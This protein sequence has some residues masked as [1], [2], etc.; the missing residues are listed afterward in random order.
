METSRLRLFSF[1]LIVTAAIALPGCDRGPASLANISYRQVGI[2]KGYDTP[3]G[4]VKA[5][6]NEAFAIFRINAIDNTKP[7]KGFT[8]DPALLYVD[9]STPAQKAGNVWNWN[10]RFVNMNPRFWQALGLPTPERMIV[11][12]GKKVEIDRFVSVPVGINNPTGGPEAKQY[13]FDFVYDAETMRQGEKTVNE[14]VAFNKINSS[15]TTWT[16]AEDCKTV[17]SK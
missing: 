4:P 16:V 3:T 6:A 12:E 14:G 13:A 7:K 5:V 9:Q 17:V 2:C 1:S 11:P 10:R 15:E 8:F